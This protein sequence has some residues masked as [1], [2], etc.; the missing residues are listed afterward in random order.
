MLKVSISYKFLIL[1]HTTP[2]Q[3]T[4]QTHQHQRL[5]RSRQKPLNLK[6]QISLRA[7]GEKEQ[8]RILENVNNI[9]THFTQTHKPHTK[10]ILSGI[11]FENVL[12]Q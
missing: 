11:R 3:Q 9:L 10:Y 2:P 5:T 8:Q 12:D 7:R 6:P 1:A 4:Q